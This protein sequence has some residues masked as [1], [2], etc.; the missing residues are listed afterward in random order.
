MA[1]LQTF[2]AGPM[3]DFLSGA[4]HSVAPVNPFNTEMARSWQILDARRQTPQAVVEADVV[5]IGTGA[6]GG[7]A[8]EMLTNAGLKVVMLEQG[9]LKTSDDFRNDEHKAYA[10]LYQEGIM[11]MTR[12]GAI[13][14]L[15]GRTVGGSTTVNWTSSFRTP[16]QTLQHWQE[17]FGLTDLTNEQL[18]PWFERLEQ[19]LQ[20]SEWAVPPNA[21]NQVIQRGCD[22]L[23]WHWNTMKRNVH[24]CANLG[25]CGTGCPINA[26]Q[27]ML[28]TTVPQALQNGATLIHSARAES[29]TWANDTVQEVVCYAMNEYLTE[30][31]S[32]RRFVVRAKQVIVAGGGINSPALLKRSKVPDPHNLAGKRTFIHPVNFSLAQFSQP[33]HGYYG[34]PQSIYSDQFLWNNPEQHHGFKLEV[35]PMH[36]AISSALLSGFGATSMARM[37]QLSH[38]NLMIALMRDGFDQRSAGGTV[39]LESNGDPVLDYP[40]NDYLWQSV[41]QSWLAM[42]EIQFAAGAKGVI[43]V[44]SR[45]ERS[46]TLS[47]FRTQI[48]N[49]SYALHDVRLAS[50]HIMGGCTMAASPERGV[51]T[52]QGRHHQLEN[53][54][55]F[56]GS[57]FPTSV[58]ANPQLSIYALTAYLIDSFIQNYAGSF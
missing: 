9:S 15:Q 58:G 50:A 41:K 54:W 56:D 27:S 48:D 6:G 8:A 14:L 45:G 16:N 24:G 35:P 32:A 7:I 47:H 33:V 37:S 12:D 26:K 55:I 25:Y 13:T 40:V 19:R 38:S 52:P 44:H 1:A 46:P 53:L 57:V 22:A 4:N 17:Q 34:A 21:N 2:P 11:R 43:P 30:T 20:I 36:P 5:I 23:G 49:L 42:A 18:A 3:S 28:T 51:V 10:E 39:E 29:L 31:D